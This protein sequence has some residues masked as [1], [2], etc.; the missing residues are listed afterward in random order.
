MVR[1]Y[2]NLM[3]FMSQKRTFNDVATS[4]RFSAETD[5]SPSRV[6]VCYVTFKVNSAP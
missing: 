1:Y 6:M 4:G 2:Y 5:L 3:S